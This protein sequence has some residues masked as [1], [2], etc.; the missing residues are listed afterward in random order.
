MI[1]TK[2]EVAGIV[3]VLTLMIV[4]VFS[5]PWILAGFMISFDKAHKWYC[6]ANGMALV[7][8]T[9]H[10]TNIQLYRACR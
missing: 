6:E 10:E 4:G 2:K 7:W 3:V 9:H 1:Y 8:V 5:I